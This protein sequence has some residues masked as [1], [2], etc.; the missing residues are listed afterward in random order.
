M[1]LYKGI[2]IILG[3]RSHKEEAMVAYQISTTV[4]MEEGGWGL[5]PTCH[6][7]TPDGR[8]VSASR[9]ITIGGLRAF[10]YWHRGG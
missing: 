4:K 7:P 5:G 8:K 3:I 9:G 1:I 2:S 6:G 10:R